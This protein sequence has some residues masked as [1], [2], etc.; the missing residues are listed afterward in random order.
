MISPIGPIEYLDP[1]LPAI[2]PDPITR[3]EDCGRIAAADHSRD[4]QLAGHNGRMRKRS[5]YV[6]DNGA[7]PREE[8]GPGNIGLDRDHDLARTESVTV[9]RMS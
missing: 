9:Q 5:T 2:H 4:A 1:P 6:G 3:L 8:Q 7:R